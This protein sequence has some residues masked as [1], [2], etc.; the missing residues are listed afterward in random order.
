MNRITALWG[1]LLLLATACSTPS[2]D[3]II[4]NGTVYAG[5][6]TTGQPLDI[7]IRDGKI[8]RLRKN[9]R[10]Q[11]GREID[12][13]GLAVSPG[14]IDLHTHLEPITL[15]PD[16]ESHLRQ[17]VTTALG[18]PD[19]G[20]PV[21]LDEYL[22]SLQRLTVG[23][24]VAYLTGHNTIRSQV[25][26]L[27][28]RAPTAEE[29]QA[30]QAAVRKGMQDGA[31]GISTGLKYLPGTYADI[32][33]VIALSE[34]AAKLGGI[35]TS[36]LR[37]EGLG[38]IEGV[39]E[40]ITIADEADIPVVLTH[41]KVVGYPMW[42]SSKRTLAMVDSARELG[43]DVMIDQYPYTAS[44][45]SL[46]IL[47]PAWSMAGGR[48]EAFTKRCEDPVL[49]DSIK[50]G[51]IFN[52]RNDRGGNDLRRVQFSKFNWKPEL[53]SK[54]L[55][56]WAVSEGLEPTLENGAELIIQAQLHRGASCIFHA[57][58][59]EDVER[60]MAHPQTMVASDG[61]VNELGR[62]HPHPRVYGTFP[63]VLGHY[64]R[65]KGILSLEEALHKMTSL[66][67]DRLGLPNRG[68]IREGYR[69]D[70]TIFNPET[71][72]DKAEFTDPHQF[73][74]GITYVLQGG[75][76][77]LEGDQFYDVRAGEVLRGPAYTTDA[78]E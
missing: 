44:Y 46:S 54:T 65:E 70:I 18:G 19:G 51:I 40:A 77:V 57:M 63:R 68:R 22:D 38:L 25:M 49:R 42:G 10:G 43:L 20:A 21:P 6:A 62:G 12:A 2:Y 55:H 31:F 61:R 16:A 73:P 29:M 47:I 28:N 75:Q 35:Y 50:R 11:A 76:I 45:T 58:D 4:R 48:Y 52:L 5:D 66:P 60:I 17:G 1:L 23:L 78:S 33:E 36:H 3:L 72:I 8:V 69:A 7:G 14:F 74:E 64:V 27:E 59:E 32:D 53:E 56:D 34:E 41:H 67:A 30:M 39:A 26:G 24:N 15:I 37:E 9:L 13:Q 71:I